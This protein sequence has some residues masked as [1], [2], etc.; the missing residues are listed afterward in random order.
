ML[1]GLLTEHFG[2][3]SIFIFTLP[4]GVLAFWLISRLPKRSPQGEAFKFDYARPAA[5]RRLRRLDAVP[6]ANMCS[7]S[8]PSE[9]PIMLALLVTAVVSFA[10]L[11]SVEHRLPAPL[12]PVDLFRDPTI[13]RANA[14]AACHGGILVS[15]LTFVPIYLRVVH[16]ASAGE[17][18]LLIV[19]MTVG[20]GVGSLITGT[21]RQPHRAD[22]DPAVL[23]AGVRRRSG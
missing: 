5:V 22:R 3:R 20:I 7:A 10:L 4:L 11:I 6:V 18:G 15:L 14:M 8:E 23:G 16:E 19:P 13:W 9:M 2:W 1:G 12:L 17:I 21:H